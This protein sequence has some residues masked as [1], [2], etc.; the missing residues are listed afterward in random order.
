MKK[1]MSYDDSLKAMEKGI[2]KGL[3]PTEAAF[4]ASIAKWEA[5]VS[6]LTAVDNSI[7][8]LCGLCILNNYED[9]SKCLV[10]E[11]YCRGPNGKNDEMNLASDGLGKA[12]QHSE[13]LLT[14]L[15][16]ERAKLT[17]KR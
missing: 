1:L 3:T 8:E 9:C 17:P 2:A 11:H 16:E 15:K 5:I 14:Y 10:N 4:E 13:S 6:T 7:G 12:I